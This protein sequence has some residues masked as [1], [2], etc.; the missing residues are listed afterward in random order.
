MIT[1]VD[2]IP[3]MYSRHGSSA[4][5]SRW[6]IRDSFYL[7]TTFVDVYFVTARGAQTG[8]IAT[9]SFTDAPALTL[10][11]S[12]LNSDLYGRRTDD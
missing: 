6:Y 3:T 8:R 4:S 7:P 11:K 2:T 1:V 9:T 12:G 10:T 5:S